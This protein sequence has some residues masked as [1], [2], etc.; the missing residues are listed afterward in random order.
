MVISP[1]PSIQQV[2]VSS[3]NDA[4]QNNSLLLRTFVQEVLK[5]SRTSGSIFQTTLCYLEAVRPKVPALLVPTSSAAIDPSGH[6]LRSLDYSMDILDLAEDRK[7]IYQVRFNA[8][9]ISPFVSN[10]PVVVC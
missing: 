7:Q 6:S 3:E 4:D 9:A 8:I 2:L 1:S 10:V 5:R